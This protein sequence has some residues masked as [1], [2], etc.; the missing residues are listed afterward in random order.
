MENF[1]IYDY[2]DKNIKISN[3]ILYK[4]GFNWGRF[5]HQQFFV[6]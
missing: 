6:L 5:L 2:K 3:K 4:T 1:K